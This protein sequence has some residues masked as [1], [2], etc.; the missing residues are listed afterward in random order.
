M[1][2]EQFNQQVLKT[3]H[4]KPQ[5]LQW[6]EVGM[7]AVLV[8]G[9]QSVALNS[10]RSFAT[11]QPELP[12]DHHT[13]DL[14]MVLR[15]FKSF[16]GC[17]RNLPSW[18]AT[19]ERKWA[20]TVTTGEPFCMA[21]VVAKL[22]NADKTRV[23][24][25]FLEPRLET[26][27]HQN[28]GDYSTGV[29]YSNGHGIVGTL[30]A[31]MWLELPSEVRN[32]I[33]ERIGTWAETKRDSA[34]AKLAELDAI[35]VAR[36]QLDWRK[37]GSYRRLS[38]QFDGFYAESWVSTAAAY[39]EKILDFVYQQAATD[40]LDAT[41]YSS[42]SL[43]SRC[44]GYPEVGTFCHWV[45]KTHNGLDTAQLGWLAELSR[46]EPDPDKVVENWG[47]LKPKLVDALDAIDRHTLAN[48]VRGLHV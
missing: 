33:R 30:R 29:D 19:F 31:A 12:H 36:Y 11:D 20:K 43:F 7:P 38:E 28:A 24:S 27:V 45:Q 14:L 5:W 17:A 16:R 37:L 3:S 21:D 34:L 35:P 44:D 32:D 13:S 26:K 1:T 39:K 42:Y 15:H 8:A 25:L 22:G 4:T 9:A 41:E 46:L 48:R 10:Y 40:G 47:T 6:Y 2:P 18:A 23:E